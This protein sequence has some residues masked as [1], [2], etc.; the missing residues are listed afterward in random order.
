M[1]TVDDIRAAHFKAVL[2]TD[3]EHGQATQHYVCREYPR[4]SV[5]R[6]RISRQSAMTQSFFVDGLQ[7][8]DLDEAAKRLNEKGPDDASPTHG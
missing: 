2:F 4:L 7:V 6:E 8:R 5:L 3:G 1:I